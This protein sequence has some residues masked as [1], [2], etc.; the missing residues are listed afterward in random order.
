MK[1][2][3]EKKGERKKKRKKKETK[4]ERRDVFPS[5]SFILS[6]DRLRNQRNRLV[7]S[8]DSLLPT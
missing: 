1:V 3:K 2:M 8:L 7:V 4:R 6:F 5:H